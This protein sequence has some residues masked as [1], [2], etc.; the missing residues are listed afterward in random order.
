MKILA[1]DLGTSQL[2]ALIMN[3]NKEVEIVITER[4][5][6]YFS[7]NG[8][9]QQQPEDW[10]TALAC[11]MKRLKKEGFLSEVTAISFSGHMSGLVAMS[12][13]KVSLYPCIT[14]SDTRSEVECKILRKKVG[15]KVAEMTGNPIINAFILPKLLWLKR[16]EPE[17]YRKMDHWILPKDYLRM[18]FTETLETDYTD[19]YNSLCINPISANWEESII[20]NA[21]LEGNKFPKV[22]S[23]WHYSETIS[24]NA[25]KKF[26]LSKDVKIFTGA[27][28]MACSALGS[29]LF[30][31]GDTALTLGTSATFLAMLPELDNHLENLFGKVTFHLHAIPGKIYA[32]GS[33]F[34]GGLVLNWFSDIFTENPK[35][36]YQEI[37]KIAEKAQKI[38]TGSNGILT[39]PFLSGSGTPYFSSSD[40]Y[41]VYG[42]T[43]QTKKEHFFRSMLEGTAYNIKESLLCFE[44]ILQ[45]KDWKILLGGGGC[46]ISLWCQIISEVLN[47]PL[48]KIENKDASAIGAALI[49]RYGTVGTDDICEDV[50][51]IVE[52]EKIY[53]PDKTNSEIYFKEF[54]RYN[55]LYQSLKNMKE[56]Y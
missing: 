5:P 27:A 30:H 9:V 1:L 11:A 16:N 48:Y 49:A 31:P 37:L 20:E 43:T 15:K 12:R 47:Q 46:N 29:G 35:N 24:P 28:D 36:D 25:A 52:I 8:H 23:P 17:I 54:E 2:K 7:A 51:E 34:N 4:Y 3:E 45:R 13:E 14:L 10:E 53:I 55:K 40:C 41:S 56:Q 19:A 32:L 22:V 21:E 39:L 18:L 33:H 26:G 42:V 50:Q 38:P 6:T 44:A